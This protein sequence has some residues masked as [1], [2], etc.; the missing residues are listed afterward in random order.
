MSITRQ[1]ARPVS[2]DERLDRN[3]LDDNIRRMPNRVVSNNTMVETQK[4]NNNYEL[5][6][7]EYGGGQYSTPKGTVQGQGS[8][9]FTKAH[10]VASS[11]QYSFYGCVFKN[12][13]TISGRVVYNNCRFESAVTVDAGAFAI[14]TGCI[15]TD[16]GQIT[17][18]AALAD[19]VATGCMRVG[20]PAHVN[21]TV[22]GEVVA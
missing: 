15:F 2:N 18:N 7:G 8:S 3:V 17:N 20:T 14:F 12:V 10:S 11:G 19:C 16:N 21:V 4:T 6:N 9:V 5:S 22:L 13:V 1:P